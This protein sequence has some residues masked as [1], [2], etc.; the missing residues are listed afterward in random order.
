MQPGPRESEA[1]ARSLVVGR[2]LVEGESDASPPTK[3]PRKK[4]P[5][6]TGPPVDLAVG[7]AVAKVV[8]VEELDGAVEPAPALNSPQP[9]GTCSFVQHSP[10]GLHAGRAGSPPSQMGE[11]SQTTSDVGNHA[12][13]A[14]LQGSVWV[15]PYQDALHQPSSPVLTFCS[16]LDGSIDPLQEIENLQLSPLKISENQIGGRLQFALHNWQKI[17]SDQLILQLVTGTPIP[18]TQYPEPCEGF[19]PTFSAKEAQQVQNCVDEM[20]AKGA[21]KVVS[22]MKGQVVS[23]IFLRPKKDGSDRPV[24]NLRR[25]NRTVKYEHFKMEGLPLLKNMLIQNDYLI[26]VDLKDAYFCVPMLGSH[27]KFLRFRWMGQLFEFQCLPFGLASAPRDFTKLTKPLMSFLRRLGFRI[28]IYLDDMLLMNQDPLRLLREGKSLIVLLRALGWVVNTNK[29][30]LVPKQIQEFLGFKINTEN[31]I[32]SLP[33]TKV[34]KIKTLCASTISQRKV[35]VRVLAKLIGTLTSTI[36][37]V[38]P[39]PLHYRHLQMT[40]I[41]A[42]ISARSYG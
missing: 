15:T 4:S 10:V 20:L 5:F 8:D 2:N 17:T 29:S 25:L 26:K 11:E 24:F 14:P 12:Q 3:L 39:A 7:V 31:M 42:L 36:L 41:R 32:M 6:Q 22:P 38:L 18:F 34:H 40:K 33:M 21:I 19:A 35:T 9:T 16:C 28:V 13:V 1:K 37:A 27:K 30:D 23:H